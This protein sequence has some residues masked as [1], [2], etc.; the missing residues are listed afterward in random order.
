LIRNAKK[1]DSKKGAILIENAIHDIANMLT[2]MDDYNDVIKGLEE[3][4]KKKGNRISYE[5][6]IVKEINKEVVGLV[7]AYHGKNASTLDKPIEDRVR[8]IKN[9]SNFKLDK[10]ADIDEYYID[11]LSVDEGYQGKGIAKE[12]IKSIEEKAKELKYEKIALCVDVENVK[13]FKLYEKVGYKVDKEI[14]IN[15]KPYYHMV[16]YVTK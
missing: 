11:T 9:D 4:Y 14:Y 2:G 10:E 16:K 15:K 7:L 3:Y 6:I 5:N 13:A 1:E 12:L 8:K